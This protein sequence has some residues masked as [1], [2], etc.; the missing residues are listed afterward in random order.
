[1]GAGQPRHINELIQPNYTPWSR[2]IEMFKVEPNDQCP[3]LNFFR[4]INRRKS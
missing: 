4:L 1:M 2:S 3:N